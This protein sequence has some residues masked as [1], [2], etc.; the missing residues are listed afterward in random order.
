MG[1]FTLMGP[2]LGHVPH[3]LIPTIS[4]NPNKI[5]ISVTAANH[6]SYQK[7]GA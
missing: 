4:E 3:F 6:A 7:L 5:D 2:L 1:S